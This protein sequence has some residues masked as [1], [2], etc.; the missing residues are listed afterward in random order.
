MKAV[1][2]GILPTDYTQ[3]ED[4]GANN[5]AFAAA[6]TIAFPYDVTVDSDINMD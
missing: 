5:I 3:D 6:A 4:T 1:F 2:G